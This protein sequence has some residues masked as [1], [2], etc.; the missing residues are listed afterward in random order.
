[1]DEFKFTHKFTDDLI[2]TARKIDRSGIYRVTWKRYGKSEQVD[3]PIEEAQQYI[4]SKVW[5]V[6]S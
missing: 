4:E 5:E 3:F 6:I 1:M 2:Y